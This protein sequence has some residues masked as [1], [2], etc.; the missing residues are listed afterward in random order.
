M[1]AKQYFLCTIPDINCCL[2]I[3]KA[4]IKFSTSC[5]SVTKDSMKVHIATIFFDCLET[6]DSEGTCNFCEI[7]PRKG[8]C[9]WAF[10]HYS[11]SQIQQSEPGVYQ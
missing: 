8:G 6:Q 1:F 2:F 9:P 10:L 11:P 7:N 5:P 4:C 3:D